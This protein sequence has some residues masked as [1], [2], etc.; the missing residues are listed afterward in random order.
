MLR[1]LRN[2]VLNKIL[3]KLEWNI[4]QRHEYEA[5]SKYLKL[6][7]ID[8][9]FSAEKQLNLP[10]D[11]VVF[12]RVMAGEYNESTLPTEFY[13]DVNLS[14]CTFVNI[15]AHVG[16]AARDIIHT[17]QPIQ[18]HLYEPDPLCYMLLE[19]NIGVLGC[20]NVNMNNKAIGLKDS[21]NEWFR[22]NMNSANNSL[23]KSSMPTIERL[24]VEREY[25]EVLNI[26]TESAKW[27]R[28][29]CR[30]FYMSDTQG[31][32]EAIFSIIPKSVLDVIW[33]GKIEIFAIKDKKFDPNMFFENLRSFTSFWI[34]RGR[35]DFVK[36]G[37][38]DCCDIL[39]GTWEIADRD[40]FDIFFIR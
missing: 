26:S 10:V 11:A 25:V 35:F 39:S 29:D 6:A 19:R 14:G 40:C 7:K 21:K 4:S 1:E 13:S 9:V 37:Y 34:K 38:E 22:D 12:P 23:I 33:A 2:Y 18:S 17:L 5:L 28:S 16:V 36:I 27:L 24:N 30:I 3:S 15:G 20:R 32:D 31:M 8:A